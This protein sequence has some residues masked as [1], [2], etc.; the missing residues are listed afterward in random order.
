MNEPVV[1]QR[2]YLPLREWPQ[3]DRDAWESLFVDGD[4]FDGAG[5]AR[6][7]AD[8]TR[9]TNR[10]HY[11]RW[12]GWLR[13]AGRLD[14]SVCPWQRIEPEAVSCYVRL[15]HATVGSV[16]LASSLVGLKVVAKAMQPEADWRWLARISNRL[17]AMAEPRDRRDDLLPSSA[18]LFDSART[19]LVRLDLTPLSRRLERVAYRD[20]LM[21]LVLAA[22]PVRLRNLAGLQLDRHLLRRNGGWDLRIPENETK[23]GQRLLYRLPDEVD[24]PIRTYVERVRPSFM[25]EPDCATL[26]V[27]FEGVPMVAHSIYCRIDLVTKRLFGQAVNP[28][29]FRAAA[30][31]TLVEAAPEQARL[32]SALLGHRYFRTT[33]R[34]YVRADQIVASRKVHAVLADVRQ[35]T[36]K[37]RRP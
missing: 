23:N 9:R 34:Y 36:A 26:W 14:A 24:G 29:R 13:N 20:T 30:A 1:G 7:W 2:L 11:A 31:T 19:E 8:A 5:P 22:A 25:P 21:V 10:Q 32:A 16:T 4:V 35:Q 17:G 27:T 15:L 3:A 18:A 12:L 33:E 37:K 28:H 6:H